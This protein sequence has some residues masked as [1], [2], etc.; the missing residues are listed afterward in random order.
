MSRIVVLGG[1]P[2]GA[3]YALA[4]RDHVLPLCLRS[5]KFFESLL[6]L[7]VSVT[8]TVLSQTIVSGEKR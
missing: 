2:C 5:S 6:T 7:T 3:L 8:C 1:G 4:L